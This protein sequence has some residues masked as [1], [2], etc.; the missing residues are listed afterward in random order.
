M[1]EKATG[2]RVIAAVIAVSA[3]AALGGTS[4]ASG[5][6]GSLG[7]GATAS[8]GNAATGSFV[9]GSRGASAGGGSGARVKTPPGTD[10]PPLVT[11]RT[12]ANVAGKWGVL[13]QPYR[14]IPI[15]KCPDTIPSQMGDE[16]F[17]ADPLAGGSS[18]GRGCS[19]WSLIGRAS[20]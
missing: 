16:C 11:V 15:D 7:S 13:L 18:P 3:A 1:F 5:S 20:N 9:S 14:N 8:L 12:M 19:C 2:R 17:Y 10:Q 6:S 4:L